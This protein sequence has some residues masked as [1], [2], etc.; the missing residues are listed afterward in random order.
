[1]TPA[2]FVFVG[3]L[4]GAFAGFIAGTIR[5]RKGMNKKKRKMRVDIKTSEDEYANL[6]A[7]YGQHAHGIPCSYYF[8]K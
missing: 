4:I 8:K 1:M 7:G 5:E 2:G 3:F 6:G